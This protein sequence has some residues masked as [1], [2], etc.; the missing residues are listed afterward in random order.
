LRK[1]REQR[2]EV[3]ATRRVGLRR[4]FDVFTWMPRKLSL[5]WR[6][7]VPKIH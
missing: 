3:Q 6:H 2:R 5:L 1:L 4:Y 7:G